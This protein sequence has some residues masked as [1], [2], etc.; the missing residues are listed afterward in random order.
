MV[1]TCNISRFLN[2]YHYCD[3][4]NM[5]HDNVYTLIDITAS[6]CFLIQER[7]GKGIG[8][9]LCSKTNNFPEILSPGGT[10]FVFNIFFCS[11]LFGR[12]P[13]GSALIWLLYCNIYLVLEHLFTICHL[14]LNV[15]L[16]LVH[17]CVTEHP[18]TL[19]LYLLTC[20]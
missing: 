16:L 14:W 2:S 7:M 13:V 3:F 18:C 6:V 1:V 5:F 10:V 9:E 15:C 11:S 8:F 17:C 20:I 4:Q 19:F 12:N